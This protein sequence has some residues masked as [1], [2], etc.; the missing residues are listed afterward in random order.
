[1]LSKKKYHIS[2]YSYE[3]AAKDGVLYHKQLEKAPGFEF[4]RP[5]Y[6]TVKVKTED[7]PDNISF[8]LSCIHL[9]Q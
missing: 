6:L 4:N 7:D 8:Y 9:G 1:M 5:R 3:D 2:E